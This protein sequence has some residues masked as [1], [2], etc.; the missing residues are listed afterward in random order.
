MPALKI[1]C[2]E[3]KTWTN[4]TGC[5][6][7]HDDSALED[8]ISYCIKPNKIPHGFLGGF[9]INLNQPAFEMERLAKAYGKERGL[10]LR[11]MILSFSKEETKRFRQHALDN[12]K[13]IADYAALYYAMEYQIIYA[14]HEDTDQYHIH[15]VMNTVSFLDGAKYRGEK[16]DYYRFQEY[17]RTFLREY[18]G[19]PL[20]VYSDREETESKT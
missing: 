13:K 10:R 6:K 4:K 2:R 15:F 20:R 19:L 5:P 9:G 12:I 1:I 11:H 17:L 14:I 16:E 18:Y 8:V 3:N 7:Y